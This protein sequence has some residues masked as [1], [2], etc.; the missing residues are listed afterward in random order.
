MMKENLIPDTL[1]RLIEIKG[2][3]NRAAAR[4]ARLK[5]KP[6]EV[7]TEERINALIKDILTPLVEANADLIANSLLTVAAVAELAAA[8]EPLGA[9]GF[10][11]GGR[12]AP[13][14]DGRRWNRRRT[15]EARHDRR[16]Q[17]GL[18]SGAIH[19]V[20]PVICNWNLAPPKMASTVPRRAPA[21]FTR[22]GGVDRRLFERV[23]RF[24]ETRADAERNRTRNLRSLTSAGDFPQNSWEGCSAATTARRARSFCVRDAHAVI[25]SGSPANAC[26][27]P[28]SRLRRISSPSCLSASEA[29]CCTPSASE[30]SMIACAS[31]WSAAASVGDRRDR[32]DV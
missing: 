13:W 14:R 22:S 23:R 28:S 27:S 20:D 11:A 31:A 5:A 24:I 25:G 17:L 19:T 3:S 15:R 7:W 8:I 12:P 18:S 26:L 10:A 30:P 32:S 29:A 1:E 9:P 21:Y 2:R 6:P 4:L 16:Q